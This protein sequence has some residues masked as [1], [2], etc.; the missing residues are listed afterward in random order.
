ME[1]EHMK[2]LKCPICE[3]SYFYEKETEEDY[4][5]VICD[6]CGSKV[7]LYGKYV[8][9]KVFFSDTSFDELEVKE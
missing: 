7:E 9:L 8:Y 3:H 1:E 5:Q 4:R 2:E 6:E